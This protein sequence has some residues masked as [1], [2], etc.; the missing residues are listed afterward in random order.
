MIRT[1]PYTRIK[2][3]VYV[4]DAILQTALAFRG[5]RGQLVMPP[6]PKPLKVDRSDPGFSVCR[7]LIL[8]LVL[9]SPLTANC[10]NQ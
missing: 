5:T 1:G 6:I 8:S 7:S 9:F 4:D 10:Q 2:P 3:A